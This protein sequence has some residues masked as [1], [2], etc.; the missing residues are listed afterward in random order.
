MFCT[1]IDTVCL[2][3]SELTSTRISGTKFRMPV[4]LYHNVI[5]RR[6]VLF[7]WRDGQFGHVSPPAVLHVCTAFVASPP[8]AHETA[9]SQRRDRQ[10]YELSLITSQWRRK[11]QS[12]ISHKPT[13]LTSNAKDTAHRLRATTSTTINGSSILTTTDRV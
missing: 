12:V 13:L 2:T 4:S 6:S 11:W 9:R 7:H 5:K 8:L 10:N 1:F 3:L